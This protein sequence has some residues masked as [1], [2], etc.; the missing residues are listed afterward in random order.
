MRSLHSQGKNKWTFC[1]IV[2]LQVA[3]EVPNRD[4]G[5]ADVG[6]AG[7]ETNYEES[8]DT[9]TSQDELEEDQ[10]VVRGRKRIGSGSSR[11]VVP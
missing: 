7:Q 11:V 4:E 6:V 1:K 8:I 9:A 3:D 2:T 10:R 5:P